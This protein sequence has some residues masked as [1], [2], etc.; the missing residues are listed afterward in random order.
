MLLTGSSKRERGLAW[1]YRVEDGSWA[2]DRMHEAMST[3]ARKAGGGQ[4]SR[5]GVGRSRGMGRAER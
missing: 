1:R 5:E 4:E 3:G 2:G